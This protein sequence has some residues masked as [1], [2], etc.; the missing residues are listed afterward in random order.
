VSFDDRVRYHEVILFERE[1]MMPSWLFNMDVIGHRRDYRAENVPDIL[2]HFLH[3]W[4]SDILATVSLP[5]SQFCI[6][7]LV[8]KLEATLHSPSH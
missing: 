1:A 5:K 6:L 7:L 3:P 2:L 8:R 4:R